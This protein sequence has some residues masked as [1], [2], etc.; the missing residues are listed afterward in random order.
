MQFKIQAVK[1]TDGRSAIPVKM[2]YGR[3][4]MM[5]MALGS[6]NESHLRLC[7]IFFSEGSM[8]EKEKFIEGRDMLKN[9]AL[10]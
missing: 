6:I 4:E 8:N 1:M 10:C 9:G 3:K 2:W 5:E 7:I